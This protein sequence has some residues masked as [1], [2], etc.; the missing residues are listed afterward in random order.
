MPPPLFPGYGASLPTRERGL[1][2]LLDICVSSPCLVAP[3]AG[4]WIETTTQASPRRRPPVAPHA[5]AWIET[6]PAA[7]WLAAS[8]PVAP[9]AGAW[10]ETGGVMRSRSGWCVAPHAGAWIETRLTAIMSTSLA[11]A[12]HAGAWIETRCLRNGQCHFVVAPHAGAWIETDQLRR[13]GMEG[14]S[15]PTRER[16]LKLPW[17]LWPAAPRGSL[18]TRER[19][20]KRSGPVPVDLQCGRSPRGSVD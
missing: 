15:L 18:P 6:H 10:I 17:P 9:H 20:L 5:G 14:G 13:R 8:V 4:A 1:K 7:V 19:G 16:G 3:H 11:V 12:P 2:R